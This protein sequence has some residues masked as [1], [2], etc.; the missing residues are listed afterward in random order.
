MKLFLVLLITATTTTAQL[1]CS[2]P[3]YRQFD[4]WIGHWEAF[5]T[6]GKKAGDSNP[7]QLYYT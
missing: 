4:F 3:E 5:G 2:R 1:P 7:R 6:N